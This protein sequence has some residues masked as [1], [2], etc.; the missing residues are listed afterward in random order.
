MTRKIPI[1][2]CK[3]CANFDGTNCKLPDLE[4]C[5]KFDPDKVY[6]DRFLLTL[7]T[8]GI[9]LLAIFSLCIIKHTKEQETPQPVQTHS[10][11]SLLR[12]AHRSELSEWQE[13]QMAI[14]LTESRFNQDA[15]GTAGDRGVLQIIPI[16]VAEANRIAGTTYTAADAHDIDKALEMF[17]IVQDYYNPTHNLDSA[18]YHHNK[19]SAY[20]ARVKNNLTFIK[21]YENV[22]KHLTK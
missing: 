11:C 13:L 8:I 21:R 6:V 20:R 16:Y 2:K 18:I 14:M 1:S 22:R 7:T 15:V 19:S 5:V 9:I 12:E 17:T 10:T 3:G 4:T